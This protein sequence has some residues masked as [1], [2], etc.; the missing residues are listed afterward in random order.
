MSDLN[1]PDITIIDVTSHPISIESRLTEELSGLVD[2]CLISS[3]S[4]GEFCTQIRQK[5]GKFKSK[6][7]FPAQSIENDL[8]FVLNFYYLPQKLLDSTTPSEQIDIYS[9]EE[10]ARIQHQLVHRLIHASSK[11]AKPEDIET[12]HQVAQHIIWRLSIM[13]KRVATTNLNIFW[14]GVRNQLA[15]TRALLGQGYRVFIPDYTQ[16]PTEVSEKENAVLQLDVLSHV[17]L[18]AVSPQGRIYLLDA[19]GRKDYTQSHHPAPKLENIQVIDPT[20]TRNPCLKKTLFSLAREV[21]HRRF[22]GIFQAV[23]FIPTQ[24]MAFVKSDL[25]ITDKPHFTP[26]E[27]QAEIQSFGRLKEPIVTDII[28]QLKGICR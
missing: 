16:D 1:S 7:D 13:D 28:S 21:C 24:G 19:K 23:L 9:K 6:A 17:D 18:V 26:H 5:V 15:I 10:N 22:S 4:L 20:T 11:F 25:G 8:N 12:A 14:A 27:R 2:E 3:H